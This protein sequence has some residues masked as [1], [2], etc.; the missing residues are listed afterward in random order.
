M[1]I[2]WGTLQALGVMRELRVANFSSHPA[3]SHILN[4]HLQDNAVTKLELAALEK[5][6]KTTMDDLKTLKGAVDRGGW[7][8]SKK[9]AAATEGGRRTTN[10]CGRIVSKQL[11]PR[12]CI[13]ETV[14]SIEGWNSRSS[15]LS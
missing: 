6:L 13:I 12:R 8:K 10:L 7:G 2:L 3:L 14:G 4:L 11:I 5:K 15:R 1:K 9:Q